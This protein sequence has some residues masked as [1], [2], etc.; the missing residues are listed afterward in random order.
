MSFD[1]TMFDYFHFIFIYLIICIFPLKLNLQ[2][3]LFL[4]E[5]VKYIIFP[6]C[7]VRE[8]SRQKR[9]M[10]VQCMQVRKSCRLSPQPLSPGLMRKIHNQHF[11]ESIGEKEVKASVVFM[12]IRNISSAIKDFPVLTPHFLVYNIA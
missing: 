4:G 7:C 11:A 5:K 6:H 10:K 9:K 1:F 3:F 2:V 8:D 12:L